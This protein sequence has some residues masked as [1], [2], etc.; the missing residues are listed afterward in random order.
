[1]PFSLVQATGRGLGVLQGLD[2]AFK[3]SPR[4][5]HE[6]HGL[7]GWNGSQTVQQGQTDL[8]HWKSHEIVPNIQNIKSKQRLRLTTW[9]ATRL[10]DGFK[11]LN[12]RMTFID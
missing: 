3:A 4:T 7:S 8:P 9:W 6:V 11:E 5:M 1:M 2:Q 12:V 10:Q